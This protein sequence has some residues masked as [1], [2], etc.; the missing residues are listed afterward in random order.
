MKKVRI[1]LLVLVA[2]LALAQAIP[3]DRTN[4]PVES[5]VQ[6]PPPV[7]AALKKSCWDCHSNETVWGWH[8]TIAP[9]SWL[10]A[11]DV[12][13]GRAE[14]NFSRWTALGARRI[15]KLAREIP[16]EV[17]EGEMPPLLY[18]LAHPSAKLAEPERAA[19]VGWA[20]TLAAGAAESPRGAGG[21]PLAQPASRGD[22]HEAGEHEEHEHR[23]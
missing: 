3:V 18:V 10:A 14:L 5:Q 2:A 16:E 23:R 21:A 9:I 11:H 8:T 22:A 12:N 4:P 13:E 6:A 15:A 1:G 19:I 17:G 20:K 7:L